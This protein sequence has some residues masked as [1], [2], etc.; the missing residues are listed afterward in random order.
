MGVP[1]SGPTNVFMDNKSVVKSAL[2]P[3][4]TLKKNHISIAYHKS[5]E[6]FAAEVIDIFWIA[7]EENLAD[8][9]TKP[10]P[11]EQRKKLFR[12]GIFH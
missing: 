7:P 3:E 5:C 4:A 2:N 6:S 12:S 10:L 11:A 1:F 8:L 9:F